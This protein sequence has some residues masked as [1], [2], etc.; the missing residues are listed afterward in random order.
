[1]ALAERRILSREFS[2][3]ICRH[4]RKGLIP[5][6]SRQKYHPECQSIRRANE[7]MKKYHE[8]PK[9]RRSVIETSRRSYEKRRRGKLQNMIEDTAGKLR[10]KGQTESKPL[11][12]AGES[13]QTTVYLSLF[14]EGHLVFRPVKTEFKIDTQFAI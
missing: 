2:P 5:T 11:F 3:I 12:Q 13:K 9:F 6:S 10:D 8:D 14:P 1:M 4:C 7:R